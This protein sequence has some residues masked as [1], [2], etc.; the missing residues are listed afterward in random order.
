[1]FMA[2][3]QIDKDKEFEAKVT[4]LLHAHLYRCI[5]PPVLY[6]CLVAMTMTRVGLAGAVTHMYTKC[7][8]S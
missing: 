5:D 1:M 4:H 6:D 8:V 3:I 2:D 7:D